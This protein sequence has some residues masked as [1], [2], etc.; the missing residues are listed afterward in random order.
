MNKIFTILLLISLVICASPAFGQ[1]DE[2]LADGLPPLT[3]RMTERIVNLYA[4][5]LNV[6]FTDVQRKRVQKGLVD[7]WENQDFKSIGILTV[8]DAD[9]IQ[10]MAMPEAERQRWRITN[11]KSF[12]QELREEKT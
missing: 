12:V 5:L 1:P 9:A 10:F 4:Y 7:Y 8:T 2:V 11:Q 3:R 6:Q